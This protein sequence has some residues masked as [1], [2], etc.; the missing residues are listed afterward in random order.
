MK[1]Q[2]RRMVLAGMAAAVVA[3]PVMAQKKYDP[4]ASD[5]EIRIGGISP[6][7]G[8]ASAY[9]AIGK[10]IQAYVNKVN[11]EGGVNGRKLNFISYDDGYNPAKTVEMARK[12][13][14]QDEVLFVFNTLGTPPNSAIHRYMNQKKVPQLFVATGATKWGDPQNFPWTM[15]WQPSYQSEAKI[16]AQHLLETK[17]NAKIAIIYQN[18]DYGKDY[19]KGFKDGLG[20]AGRKLIVAEATYEVTDP[21]IDSQIVTLKGS[22]ADA[23]FNITTPKFAAQAIKKMAEIGWKPVHYLNSVSASVGAVIIPAGPQNAVDI[24]TAAY[25]MDPTDAQWHNTPAYKGWLEW[26]QKYNP[27][28][29]LKD[30]NNVYGYVVAQGLIEVL[31]KAGDNLTRENIMKQAA[32][33]DIPNI[34]MMLPGVNVKTSADD[35]YPIEREQLQR[36]D[37]KTWVLFGKTYGR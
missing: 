23:F 24:I 19:L 9:G 22:G 36:W 3:S 20:E 2:I 14:E 5:T 11:A 30:A 12:L 28:G 31:K 18:D 17:P 6:Y 34:P 8:P 35:F 15:G 21:T 27:Q 25:L 7:S 32:S 13:V 1:S 29:D 33:L 10:A 16:F 37:G 4:G 26:M